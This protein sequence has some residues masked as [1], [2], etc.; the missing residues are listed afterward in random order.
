MDVHMRMGAWV[1]HGAHGEVRRQLHTTFLLPLCVRQ[2]LL[3][4]SAFFRLDDSLASGASL[5]CTFLLVPKG[6]LG[7]QVCT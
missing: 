6:M 7:V 5:A 1:G 4:T 2:G 3:L